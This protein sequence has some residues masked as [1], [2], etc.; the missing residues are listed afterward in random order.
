MAESILHLLP[1]LDSLYAY[2]HT[3]INMKIKAVHL[4]VCDI[5]SRVCVPVKPHKSRS[6]S[7]RHVDM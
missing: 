7:W 3:H 6:T 2:T 5:I 4:N 1:L